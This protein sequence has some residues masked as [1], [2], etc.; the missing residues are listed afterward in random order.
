MSNQPDEGNEHREEVNMENE[1]VKPGLIWAEHKDEVPYVPLCAWNILHA[2][3]DPCP[4]QGIAT[5]RGSNKAECFCQKHAEAVTQLAVDN[6]RPA[7]DWE[8]I[9]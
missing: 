3:D 6:G 2:H 9:I 5:V 7:P 1:N 4:L 8:L